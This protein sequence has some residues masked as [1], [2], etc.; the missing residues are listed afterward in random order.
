[1][2]NQ[3]PDMINNYPGM[4]LR[5][6]ASTGKLLQYA[7]NQIKQVLGSDFDA[8]EYSLFDFRQRI[9]VEDQSHI[10]ATIN[11]AMRAKK[12]WNVEYRIQELPESIWLRE[13]AITWEDEGY[14]IVD[15][16]AYDVSHFKKENTL[17]NGKLE[18]ANT[19]AIM[20]N[21]Y[22]ASMSHEIRTPMNAVMGMAQILEKTNLDSEQ[23]QY[24]KTINDSSIALVQIINDILDLSK[25]EAGKLEFFEQ[26]CDLEKLCLDICHLLSPRANE[27]GLRLFI[28]FSNIAKKKVNVD[29]G[30]LRQILINLIGNAIKFTESGHVEVSIKV[31]ESDTKK[32]FYRFEIID[33]GIGISQEAQE[34]VFDAF[35]QANSQIPSN[36][37]GTGLGLQIC[38]R[39]VVL[40]GGEIGVQS[41]EGEG[42]TFWFTLPLVFEQIDVSEWQT[43]K[44][45]K[46]MLIDDYPYS[47]AH[48]QKLLEDKGVDVW[49]VPDS[50]DA[51]A[52]LSTSTGL[53]FIIISKHMPTLNGLKF[54]NLIKND[55]RYKSTPIIM[56]N[57]FGETED[58]LE[59][60]NNGVNVYFSTP[61]TST[62][63][64]RAIDAAMEYAGIQKQAIYFSAD[65]ISEATTRENTRTHYFGKALIV[66]DVEINR[67]ILN[68]MLS[69]IGLISDLASN[70]QDA[71]DK[72]KNNEYD[73]VFM[74]C[75][76]PIMDGYEATKQIRSLGTEKSNTTIIALT[77][78]AEVSQ[79][80]QCVE[81]GMNE[82]LSKPY[83]EQ[84]LTK[85]LSNYLSENAIVSE[86]AA[87]LVA[88]DIDN[89]IFDFRQFGIIRETLAEEFDDYALGVADNIRGYYVNMLEAMK[90]GQ[91]D[92]LHENA[93]AL[94]G[95]AGLIGAKQ[96]AD[97]SLKLEEASSIR[98]LETINYNLP[99]LDASLI[100]TKAIILSNV[101]PEL[102]ESIILF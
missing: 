79:V 87:P 34:K 84:D 25:L 76:M 80:S 96:I 23:K 39:L 100:K 33:T 57:N 53:D 35:I 48:S 86:K 65:S 68:A 60:Y 50:D 78:N 89:D 54:A 58:K 18:D 64:Y 44:D 74:D 82:Y 42:S 72:V 19:A 21:E 85:V 59:I 93:H 38:Q 56:I 9:I 67:Y 73:I 98:D 83:T 3:H 88:V 32:P 45:K 77:A 55:K 2:P 8:E 31:D 91:L 99:K 1:M 22:F 90:Q 75:R 46:C 29:I 52:L 27:R 94:K 7:G 11:A 71:V 61:F 13:Q 30:R 101:N 15:I 12:G 92:D 24:V 4:A 70:G 37:G 6:N 20:K 40:M 102:D 66:D 5:F 26:D 10:N 81:S 95:L 41:E 14:T 28:K 62:L 51:V 97:L 69:R 43:L 47:L 49:P 16:F 63:F 17:L 36:F